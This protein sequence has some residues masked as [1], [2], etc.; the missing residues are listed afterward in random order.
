MAMAFALG[1]LLTTV[2]LTGQADSRLTLFSPDRFAGAT[3]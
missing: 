2:L 3:S 1:R